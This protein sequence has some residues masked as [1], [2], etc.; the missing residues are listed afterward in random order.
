MLRGFQ[1]P[2]W[3]TRNWTDTPALGGLDWFQQSCDRNTWETDTSYLLNVFLHPV[4][5]SIDAVPPD[6]AL[7]GNKIPVLHTR[8]QIQ[9]KLHKN[10]DTGDTRDECTNT[11]IFFPRIV[12]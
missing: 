11:P 10:E 4:I 2:T 3:Q 1:V 12:L 9:E 5:V 7:L 6:V 8:T